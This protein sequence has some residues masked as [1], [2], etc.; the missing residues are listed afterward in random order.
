MAGFSLEGKRDGLTVTLTFHCH[1]QAGVQWAEALTGMTIQ[2]AAQIADNYFMT[3]DT[4]PDQ[5]L[6]KLTEGGTNAP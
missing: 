6:Q 2:A 4:D 3:T 1:D 5:F